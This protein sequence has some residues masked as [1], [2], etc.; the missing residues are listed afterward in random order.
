MTAKQVF[1][2]YSR[3]LSSSNSFT[4]WQNSMAKEPTNNKR[5]DVV[6][7]IYLLKM[8]DYLLSYFTGWTSVLWC[9]LA[10]NIA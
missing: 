3:F 9:L 1:P 10:A 4:V 2:I 7:Q 5:V 8:T 6:F